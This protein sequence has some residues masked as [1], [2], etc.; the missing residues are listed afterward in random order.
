MDFIV[1]E[2]G[3]DFVAAGA[4][5][6]EERGGGDVDAAFALD[7]FDDNAAGFFGDEFVDGGFVVVGRVFESWYHG[8][9]R[10]LVFWIWG[11]G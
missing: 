4:K 5:R 10:L 1:D 11:S 3:A 8:R 6:L 2:D 7:G 9:E